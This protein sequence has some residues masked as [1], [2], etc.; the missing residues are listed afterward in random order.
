MPPVPE[1]DET[2]MR[3]EGCGSVV[4]GVDDKRAGRDLRAA[5]TRQGVGQKNSAQ[6]LPCVLRVNRQSPHEHCGNQRVARQFFRDEIG[7]IGKHQACRRERVETGN[8]LF[9]GEENEACGGSS[10]DI[11]RYPMAEIIIQLFGAAPEGG[12][13]ESGMQRDDAI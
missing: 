8:P 5:H 9:P 7:K 1:P 2:V 10:P 13:V 12:T 11:L 4:L 6:T 3:I